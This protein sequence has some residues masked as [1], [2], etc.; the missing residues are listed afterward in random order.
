MASIS[1][2]LYEADA[3]ST[4]YLLTVCATRSAGLVSLFVARD[5]IPS[6]DP[7]KTQ[8]FFGQTGLLAV[9]NFEYCR[10]ITFV[11][12]KMRCKRVDED[13]CPCGNRQD[14]WHT[15]GPKVS[16]SWGT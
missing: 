9:A 8:R 10:M 1:T 5:E 3:G 7:W 12:G 4:D 6:C 13:L 15:F 14:L 16:V 11:R 2:A